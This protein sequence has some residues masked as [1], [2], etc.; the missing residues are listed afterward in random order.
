MSDPNVSAYGAAIVTG[1]GYGIGRATCK[2]LAADGWSVL[3]V[4][5]DADRA[6]ETVA[7]ISASG[8]QGRAFVGDVTQ[9]ATATSAV[10]QAKTHFGAI[11]G[12]VTCA[13]MRHVGRINEITSEQWDATLKVILYGAFNF[14]KAVIPEMIA[15]GGGSIVNVSSPDAVGRRGMVAYSAAKAAVNALTT[16]LATDHVDEGIRVNTVLPGFTL[17]GMT[18]HYPAERLQKAGVATV[19]RRAGTPEDAA[20]L[21]HFLMS[22]AGETYTGGLFGNLP[23]ANRPY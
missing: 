23:L 19:A 4:D 20:Q 12:L 2:L 1:G 16:C 22:K 11:K 9:P 13:A 3:V 7:L 8:G 18:E 10:T 14:C 21:I 17:S 6:E 5:R 15:A